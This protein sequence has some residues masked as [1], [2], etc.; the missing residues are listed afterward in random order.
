MQLPTLPARLQ[1]AFCRRSLHFAFVW[2]HMLQR[3]WQPLIFLLFF[4]GSDGDGLVCA[5]A[6]GTVWLVVV[7]ILCSLYMPCTPFPFAGLL[8]PF[9]QDC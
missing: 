5:L 8:L 7:F 3:G 1:R 6:L 2:L 9:R 4:W